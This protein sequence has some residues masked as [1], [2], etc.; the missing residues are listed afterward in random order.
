[1]PDK[2]DVAVIGGGAAGLA[3]S[4]RAARRGRH[5][6][7][8]DRMPRLGK[9]ILITGGG[10]CNLLNED[11]GSSAFTATETSVVPSVF[12][13]FGRDSIKSFFAG[14]GLETVSEADGRVF[15]ATN[16]AGSVLKVLEIEIRRVGLSVECGFE[17][18]KI[19][20]R[21]GRFMVAADDGRRIE[22][23]S[24][25]LACGG[26][27]YP[28]LGSNGSGYDLARRF[29][30][31]IVLPVP[32]AVPLLVKDPWCHILQGQKLR[33]RAR[34]VIGGK[35]AGAA[36]GEIL[37]AQY[38]LSGTAV[39]DVSEPLSL[40][41]H[42]EGRR[43]TSVVA[44]FVPFMAEAALASELHK[45]MTAGWTAGELASGILP[46]KFGKIL[47]GVVSASAG[48]PG[49][50]GAALA[51]ELK[52]RT[53]A[54]TGTRGWNE[55]EFTSG[56]VDSREVDPETLESLKQPGLYLA[57]EILDVQG[58]RGG[59]NLAWAW[60]SGLLAGESATA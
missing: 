53:F 47:A 23:G 2:F 37:L 32:S 25:I 45:R 44:D 41:L 12:R 56:G 38:G 5:I 43:D 3:A 21:K 35:E 13:R 26:K 57:G 17:A 11:L 28:A 51:A 29:G 14:L 39:L 15:P 46:E 4:I 50:P 42:R 30:H 33:A 27:S 24:L 20:C 40:A 55:A 10:R 48:K 54:V 19:D 49:P 1:V 36:E 9:K 22:A 31:G 16:Q 34:A 7:V 6:V 58:R 59:Y 18:V 60:A 8:C 52:N